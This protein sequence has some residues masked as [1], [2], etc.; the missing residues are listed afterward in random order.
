[1]LPGRSRGQHPHVRAQV[2]GFSEPLGEPQCVGPAAGAGHDPLGM[3]VRRPRESLRNQ[4]LACGHANLVC[5]MAAPPSVIGAAS[6]SM[7]S[8][9]QSEADSLERVL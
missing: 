6:N 2:H 1:M 4:L 5:V 8:V 7:T 3:V 9:S